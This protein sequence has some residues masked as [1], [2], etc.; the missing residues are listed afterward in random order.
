MTMRYEPGTMARTALAATVTAA[1]ALTPAGCGPSP[2]ADDAANAGAGASGPVG[3]AFAVTTD[4][5]LAAITGLGAPWAA[6]TPGDPMVDPRTNGT[7]RVLNGADGSAQVFSRSDGHVWQV[8][9]TTG[10]PNNCGESAPLLAAVP[11]LATLLN[12]GTTV[13]EAQR[14]TI[15]D[16]LIATRRTSV[17][18]RGIDVTTQG[19]CIHW[20]T[21]A[22]PQDAAPAA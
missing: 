20:L 3:P 9:L 16:G 13:P 8:K 15:N 21:L 1:L 7:V 22:V 18:L 14:N 17:S 12:P 5:A 2:S 6:A 19:G 10:A 4:A 11:T